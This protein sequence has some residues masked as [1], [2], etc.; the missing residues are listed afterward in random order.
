[1][2]DVIELTRNTG[3][4]LDLMKADLSAS[5]LQP[6]DMNARVMEGPERGSTGTSASI[7]GYVIPYYDVIGR[8]LAFYRVKLFDSETKYRQPKDSANHLYFPKGF[9]NLVKHNSTIIIT[10][11]EKKAALATKL[12]YPTVALSGV[13]SWRTRIITLPGNP[14]LKGRKD[15]IQA[16]LKGGEEISEDQMGSLATGFQDLVDLASE[17]ESTIVIIFDSDASTGVKPQVQRAAATL[18]F[19]L[20]SKGIPFHRI[21]QL[22]LPWDLEHEETETDKLGLD[23]YLLSEDGVNKFE[24]HLKR[25]LEKRTAFPRHPAIM[26]YV[27]KRLGKQKLSRKEAQHTSLAILC[28]LDS[29]GIRLRSKDSGLTYYFD[30]RT[31]TLMKVGILQGFE[32]TAHDTPFGALLYQ[33][34]GLS[35]ADQR[36]LVWLS[37]QFNAEEPISE[38]F[39]QRVIARLA[40]SDDNVRY[41]INDG[42]Y[43]TVDREGLTIKDNGADGVMFEA[44]H[45][46]PLNTSKLKD[47]WK[48][49]SHTGKVEPWWHEVLSDVRLRDHD[50]MQKVCTLLF[51]VSPWLFRW[52]GTQLPIELLLGESGSGKSTLAGLRLSIITGDPRLRPTPNDIKDWHASVTNAGGL[53]VT[54]NVQLTDK[55]LRQRLSDELCRLVTEPNPVVEMRKYYTNADVVRFPVRAVFGLTAIA[56]P[57][58]NPDVLQRSVIVELDKPATGDVDSIIYDMD[59]TQKHMSKYGGREAWIAHHLFVLHHFFQR[60]SREWDHRYVAKHRLVNLE[61]CLILMGKVFGWDTSWVPEY[62]VGILNNNITQADWAFSGIA[63]FMEEW[64]KIHEPPPRGP[65]FTANEINAWALGHEDYKD[66]DILYSTR[67]LGRYMQQHKSMLA[68]IVGI[69]EAGKVGNRVRY[70]YVNLGTQ[71]A[72]MS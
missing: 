11:G 5:G 52:R 34:F 30:H 43:V 6:I 54:D 59:W 20:R 25:T 15:T 51:Y 57:F 66:C 50:K 24:G 26:D 10:E 18:G 1:M 39:P 27:G 65:F 40:F 23:D 41:Q 68:S 16:K 3:P 53:H 67:R 46:E 47:A 19:E 56:Q 70:R 4:A 64:K 29:S 58:Q 8:P 31:H 60:V 21:R 22:I 2:A 62:L 37:A 44:G 28:E 7:Q 38:V 32:D 9:R 48:R 14:E 72:L 42:Q 13:D 63:E 17:T 36:V 35:A 55:Q 45:V 71:K 69:V 33:R 61:Q 12:G 49:L